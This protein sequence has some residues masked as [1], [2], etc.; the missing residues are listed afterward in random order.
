[1]SE[2]EPVFT[3]S[4]A[5]QLKRGKAK[6][7]KGGQLPYL[8]DI[9]LDNVENLRAWLTGALRP[10]PGWHVMDFERTSVDDL[11]QPCTLVVANGR[12]TRRYRFRSQ[13]ELA[14]AGRLE[15]AVPAVTK[16]ELRPPHLNPR[17]GEGHDVWTA[18]CRI[19]RVHVEQ[20]ETEQAHEWME[21][22][23]GVAH[24][25]E[26]F[27]FADAAERRDAL[28]ALHGA[29]QFTR[30]DA[31]AICK[32]PEDPWPRRPLCVVDRVSADFWVRAGEA[33][34]YLR[35]IVGVA[36][37]R[38]RTLQARWNEIGIERHYYQDR[39]A[40]HPKAVLYRV[41]RGFLIP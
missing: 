38:A 33:A 30:L 6:K 9:V 13:S 36:P 21:S 17:A 26:G 28:M 19:A 23:L 32:R 14:S 8:D 18:L 29:P 12:E 2:P 3:Q 41:P 25:L 4:D 16:G 40:P 20:D 39:K 22:L 5:E 34:A 35:H 24:A 11:A 27:S 31:L 10:R 15:V 7:R 37:L 1:M